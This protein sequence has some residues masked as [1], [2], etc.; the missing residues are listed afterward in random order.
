MHFN[1]RH[2]SIDLIT[3]DI[4]K[5]NLHEEKFFIIIT[6]VICAIMFSKI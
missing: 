6:I 1:S 2:E 5:L 4:E 3:I